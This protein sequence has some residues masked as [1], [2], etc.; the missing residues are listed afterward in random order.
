MAF[1]LVNP[2]EYSSRTTSE[3]NPPGAKISKPSEIL[4]DPRLLSSDPNDLSFVSDQELLSLLYESTNKVFSWNFLLG[5]GRVDS[6]VDNTW[7]HNNI[8]LGRE[9]MAARERAVLE[10]G[11]LSEPYEKL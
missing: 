2:P 9:L 10:N 1:F 5:D 6:T 4:L 8:D 3:S 7:V 11:G